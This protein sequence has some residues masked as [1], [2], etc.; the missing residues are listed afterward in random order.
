MRALGGGFY[1]SNR[2]HRPDPATYPID[3][4]GHQSNAYFCQLCGYDLEKEPRG[5]RHLETQH[6]LKWLNSLEK[7]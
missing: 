4:G 7:K 5:Y 2:G 3:L 1:K 6:G